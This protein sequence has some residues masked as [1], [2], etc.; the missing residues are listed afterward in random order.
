MSD[1]DK[2]RILLVDDEKHL[3]LSLRDYL[4]FE[5]FDVVM[6][7]SGEEALAKLDSTK[8]DLIVLDISMPG[9]GGVGFLRRISSEDGTPEYP[10]LVLTARSTMKDFFDTVTVDGF[11]SKPCKETDLV[12]KIRA[13]LSKKKITEEK[14]ERV[15]KKILLAEDDPGIARNLTAAINEAGYE[16]DI[17]EK[18]PEVLEKAAIIKPDLFVLKELLPGLNGSAIIP[19]LK[20][21]PSVNTVPVI[22]YDESRANDNSTPLLSNKAVNKILRNAQPATIMQAVRE[23]L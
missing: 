13:I 9:M 14:R 4:T 10:V 7:K 23:V 20:I 21:M 1:S 6:A 19:M 3:L 11:L 22:L 12:A 18:G 5:N 15:K 16:V 17:V 2:R 8:P